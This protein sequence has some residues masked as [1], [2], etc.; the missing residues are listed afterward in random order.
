MVSLW[1]ILSVHLK[2]Y[3]ASIAA[4]FGSLSRYETEFEKT[5]LWIASA[6]SVSRRLKSTDRF[7]QDFIPDE[8]TR[9]EI[10]YRA[11]ELA[12]IAKDCELDISSVKIDCLI[13]LASK[14]SPSIDL[15]HRMRD[16][17]ETMTQELNAIRFLPASID[18]IKFLNKRVPFGENVSKAFP[19]CVEDIEE[20]H[21]CFAFGQYT[22]TAF[23]ISRVMEVVVRI[24]A[25]KMRVKPA[26]DEWQNYIN[27]M[28]EAIKKMPFKTPRH[29]ARRAIYSEASNYL[30]NFKE[31]FRNK[32]MHPKKTYNRK[33][34]LRV[35]DS[36]GDFLRY[37]SSEI[38]KAKRP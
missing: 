34:S 33:E 14:E 4:Q 11:T 36:A 19:N 26:R 22:A 1:D 5:R 20:A 18:M 15:Q 9:Q 6:E 28:D 12:D 35:I 27:A 2:A 25:T 10:L 3:A 23:H 13:E 37:V 21:Q 32:T 8:K 38:F 30:F 16:V 24:V 7:G 31:A 29:K 17:R